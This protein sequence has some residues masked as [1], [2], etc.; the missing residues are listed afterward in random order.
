MRVDMEQNKID[1]R[2][3][4]DRVV[5]YETRNSRKTR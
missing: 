3:I 5:S 4:E 1:F 2:L